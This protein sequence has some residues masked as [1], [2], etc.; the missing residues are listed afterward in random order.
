MYNNIIVPIKPLNPEVQPPA[1]EPMAIDSEANPTESAELLPH[2]M[3]T[4][5]A[6]QQAT[7]PAQSTE[8]AT[9]QQVPPA[10]VQPSLGETAGSAPEQQVPAA[11]VQ[12]TIPAESTGSAPEQQVP[13]AAAA[14]QQ[15]IPAESTGSA[16]Q[17]V[18]AA[19]VQQTNPA[20]STGSATQQVPTHGPPASA[21]AQEAKLA[22]QAAVE[23]ALANPE[24]FQLQARAG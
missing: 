18:P 2:V 23:Q 7:N 13:A 17:Q 11:A 24:R 16:P 3:A 4:A 15:T 12:Q 21:T 10:A 5:E 9:Q 22:R 19:A 14:V 8:T 20:E 6:V 1:P